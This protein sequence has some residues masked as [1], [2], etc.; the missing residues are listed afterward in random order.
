MSDSTEF[1]AVRFRL[2]PGSR[3]KHLMLARTAG[4]CRYV[5]NHFLARNKRE[6]ALHRKYPNS[7]R[8]P[9]LTFQSLGVEFTKLRRETPWL[10]ALPY[11]PVRYALKYQ[12]DAWKRAFA[13]GG[14]PRFKARLGNDSFTIPGDEGITENGWLRVPKIGWVKLTRNGGNPHSGCKPIRAVVKRELGKWYCVVFYD[15]GEI[16]R[17]D[18]GTAIGVDM[19]VGQVAVSDGRI[20][21]MPDVSRLEVRR[22]RYQRVVARRKRGSRRRAIAKRRA[23]KAARR[24]AQI[25]HN[26]AH[27]VSREI[28]DAAGTVVVEELNV[29]GMTRSAIGSAEAPG[30]NVRQ[31]AGLN[32]EILATGW[33]QLF[34][35]LDYK[36]ANVVSVRPAYTSQTCNECGAVDKRSR[37]TQSE[38]HC[39]HCGHEANADI[40]AALSIMALGTGAAGRGGGGITRPVKRQSHQLAA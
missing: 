36:A 39:V 17:D 8:K 25:R 13:H 14:F 20:F 16:E 15:V 30:T 31:K 6:Y 38:F 33:A 28:A 26:F 27:C 32:R 4:A 23:A 11:A 7:R 19:N 1:R 34:R 18:D 9:S 22:R 5:W 35:M 21:G 12:A 24:I 37:K 10:Q 40:N 2:H 29:R 3:D